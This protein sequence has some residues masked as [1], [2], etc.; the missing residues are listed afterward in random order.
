MTPDQERWAEAL[1]VE[2]THGRRAREYAAERIGALIEAGDRDGALRW[3]QI[4]DRLRD[5]GQATEQ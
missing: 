2:K 3:Q 1:Q 4:Y 5:L